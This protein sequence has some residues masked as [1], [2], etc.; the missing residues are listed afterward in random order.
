MRHHDHVRAAAVRPA[1]A[2]SRAGPEPIGLT[3]LALERRGAVAL[4]AT[5]AVA[6]A[7]LGDEV[8]GEA[9][10]GG[11][12]PDDVNRRGIVR[13]GGGGQR[14]GRHGDRCEPRRAT[15]PQVAQVPAVRIGATARPAV[16]IDRP[17]AVQAVHTE[18]QVRAGRGP[19][20]A[21]DPDDLAPR[22]VLALGDPDARKVPVK[23][24][25]TIAVVDLHRLPA[26][27]GVA[28]G[29]EPVRQDDPT[30]RRGGDLLVVQAIVV[31]VVAGV[32]EI[33]LQAGSLRVSGAK[34][35][36][37][38]TDPG[39]GDDAVIAADPP[40]DV[41]VGPTVVEDRGD[42]VGTT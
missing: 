12:L 6:D 2:G 27:T 36:I 4:A 14:D 3:D 42:V 33:V 16:R 5:P 1:E 31:A 11:A 34:S 26:Q 9:G 21:G 20:A 10:A 13:R 17:T 7:V 22:D 38:P 30:R 32:V 19:G 37:G 41:L 39:R 35:G 15:D 25:E 29:H 8:D 24:H 23:G 18:M 28:A 40:T